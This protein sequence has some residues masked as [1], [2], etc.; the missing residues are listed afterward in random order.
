MRETSHEN[1]LDVVVERRVTTLVQYVEV[2]VHG[3]MYC[4]QDAGIVI[5]FSLLVE[6]LL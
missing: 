4:L 1:G 6:M 2:H 5:P 3:R